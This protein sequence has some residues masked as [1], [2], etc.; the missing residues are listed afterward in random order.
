MHL[1]LAVRSIPDQVGG[2]ILDLA[3]LRIRLRLSINGLPVG[4]GSMGGL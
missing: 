3:D 2:N 1:T 4:T